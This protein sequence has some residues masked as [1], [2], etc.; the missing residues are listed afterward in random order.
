MIKRRSFLKLASSAAASC[1][2]PRGLH[3]A[4]ASHHPIT[5]LTD[6]VL[7]MVGTGWRGHTFPGAVAPFGL[8][9]LSPDTAGPPEPRWNPDR[10]DYTGWNHCS[11]YHYSD[12]IVLGFSHTHVQG[13]GG[14]ELG[15]LLLM[16]IVK[17]R[18][19]SWIAGVP[20]LQAEMQ[21]EAL[22]PNS[23]WVFPPDSG[24]R[25][26][27]RHETETASPGF[28]S[29]ELDTPRVHAELTAT[30]RCG[31][32][33]YTFHQED[34]QLQRGL[35]IDFAH[36]LGAHVE[37]AEVTRES[38]T[39]ISGHRLTSGW[40]RHREFYFV[41]ELSEAPVSLVAHCD[42]ADVSLEVGQTVRG[43]SLQF[44]ATV[45]LTSLAMS[46]RVG[47]SGTGIEGARRNL[48]AEMPHG[49]FDE[50]RRSARLL[51]TR[52]LACVDASFHEG[53]I[54]QTF[55]TSVYHSLS[56]P[57]TYTDVD[58]NYRGQDQRNHLALD[59]TGRK[60]QRYTS[61]SI[62]DV[63]RGQFPFLCITQPS[64]VNDIV[65]TLVAN[66]IE[67]NQHTLPM[68]TLWGNDTWSMDGFHAAAM[69]LAA[70]VRGFRDF[71][72]KLA[73]AG[74]MDS[75]FT[76]TDVKNFRTKQKTFRDAGYVPN[77]VSFTLDLAY[78][79]WCAGTFAQLLGAKEESARLL[80]YA[81]NYRNLFDHSTGF[82]RA[83]NVA[84]EWSTNPFRPDEEYDE[85]IESDAWQ[86]S[87]NAPHDIAGLIALHG[88][89]MSFLN[90]LEQLFTAPSF[91]IGVRPD[92]SGMVGQDAQGN[93]PS[94]WHPYLFSFAGA[95]WRTQYWVR[96]VAG[97]YNNT[98]N[99]LPGN[100]DC[101]Q[102][103]CWLTFA[104]LGFYPV[105]AA[106]GVYVLGSPMVDRATL[107]NELNGTRF[108]ITAYNNSPTNVYI[109]S[110][111]LNGK[112]LSRSWISHSEIAAGGTLVF[113]MS[114]TPN[115]SW[116][117]AM[118]ARPPSALTTL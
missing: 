54:R 28:Y 62:W 69:I 24:Y 102:L 31:A 91:V 104:A 103:S 56:A 114:A 45:P 26:F 86:S 6:S 13:T 8:V 48:A 44:I 118:T 58:G 22:G 73:L 25:S 85:Y 92:V 81:N 98:P 60:V 82:M 63:Y 52:A 67:L 51:W 87:F 75:A 79:C 83:R 41:L 90:K 72:T 113:R 66:Y 46:V 99:G 74:M 107:H 106:N 78:D 4:E 110:V 34:V 19:W 7:P 18:N 32:H 111:A 42:G 5:G 17:G 33:R 38:I 27:F 115:K 49:D 105:N 2:L 109:Q 37:S 21:A 80:S 94:H 61:L 108:E 20:D 55:A 100:D 95:P 88:G 53:A 76:G 97:I 29:V 59:S 40:A 30:T 47:I 23:G 116:G 43:A 36:A 50:N 117:T 16:P 89:D 9:Q 84:G 57:M 11:G 93:E 10:G 70:Y 77:E 112:Q 15:D 12:N 14:K 101:G 39:T 65:N 68:W 1:A 35:L 96:R 3:A 64:R 71:D